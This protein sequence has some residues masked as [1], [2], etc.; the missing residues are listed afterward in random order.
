MKAPPRSRTKEDPVGPTV[1][2]SERLIGVRS[3]H[4]AVDDDGAFRLHGFYESARWKKD[5]KTS[6]ARCRLGIQKKRHKAPDGRC[7]CGLYALHPWNADHCDSSATGINRAAHGRRTGRGLGPGAA[8][9]G[10]VSSPVRATER[11]RPDRYG[12][13]LT[14]RPDRP[15]ACEGPS[16]A[17]SHRGGRRGAETGLRAAWSWA[18]EGD[19]CLAV[20]GGRCLSGYPFLA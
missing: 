11:D 18:D 17:A 20:E 15:G 14:L 3:W 2:V 6:W 8:P 4:L 19:R 5:G 10:G 16:S 1:L 7:S 13:E 9:H 12:S